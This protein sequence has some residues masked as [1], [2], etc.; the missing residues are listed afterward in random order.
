MMETKKVDSS[1][2]D[3]KLVKSSII[4]DTLTDIVLE[5]LTFSKNDTLLS[6][7]R[8]WENSSCKAF[9]NDLFC[10]FCTLQF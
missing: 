10:F 3:E 4:E 2:E 1:Q 6:F 7:P 5:D 9:E 8:M